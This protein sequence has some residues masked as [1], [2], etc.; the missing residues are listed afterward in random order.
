[1]SDEYA[2]QETT[3]STGLIQRERSTPNSPIRRGSSTPSILGIK[4]KCPQDTTCGC[5]KR[6]PD[7]SQLYY[8]QL[9][10]QHFSENYCFICDKRFKKQSN[11]KRHNDSQHSLKKPTHQ[12]WV[13]NK[14]FARYE[15]LQEH[16][17]KKHSII[18]CRHCHLPF[19]N[20]QELKEHVQA[21]HRGIKML[22]M[23]IPS[24]KDA[25]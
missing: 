3:P 10:L 16:Q 17:L 9:D 6:F 2:G 24:P 25:E 18:C 22:Q 23:A 7:L 21:A 12:C 8:H 14:T 20:R 15:N 5:G 11:F 1:M 13:C 19:S 4:G